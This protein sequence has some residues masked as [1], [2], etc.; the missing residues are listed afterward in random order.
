[1]PTQAEL[2][3]RRKQVAKS[4]ASL[5]E[6]EAAM[7]AQIDALVAE[8]TTRR[9]GECRLNNDIRALSLAQKAQRERGRLLHAELRQLDA[10]LAPP[11]RQ[12]GR[13]TVRKQAT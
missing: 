4:L 2:K 8:A 12:R 7:Q 3:E 11:Q 9:G 5:A 10:E 13:A 1:M 6:T